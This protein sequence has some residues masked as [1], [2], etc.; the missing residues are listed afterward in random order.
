M[1][2]PGVFISSL[3]RKWKLPPHVLSNLF[4]RR[5]LDDAICPVA[6]GRRV[7]PNDYVP[8]IERVLRE[9]GLIGDCQEV[10]S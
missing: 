1:S 3:A 6:G 7:I 9:R 10:T 8:V 5:V 2:P 4:Y